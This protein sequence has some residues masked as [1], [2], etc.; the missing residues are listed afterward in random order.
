ML[1]WDRLRLDYNRMG[2]GNSGQGRDKP[3]AERN[4]AATLSIWFSV[5]L[6]SIAGHDIVPTVRVPAPPSW[7]IIRTHIPKLTPISC[8]IFILCRSPNTMSHPVLLPSPPARW[9]I[10]VALARGL[11]YLEVS[12][13]E[14]GSPRLP[15]GSWYITSLLA[16]RLAIS[17]SLW[18]YICI[19]TEYFEL[20]IRFI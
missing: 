5:G 6:G 8:A 13:P 7:T 1:L 15:A 3:P 20:R 11:L 10:G 16:G 9:W 17:Q 14:Y 12:P 2:I 18:P 4:R 19:E